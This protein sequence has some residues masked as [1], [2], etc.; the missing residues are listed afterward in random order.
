VTARVTD[1]GLAALV[2]A[3]L[4][5]GALTLFAGTPGAAWLFAVHDGCGFAIALLVIVKLRRV[6]PRLS[7]GA[8]DVNRRAPGIGAA[9]AVVTCLVAGV[10][11]S[12]GL[13]TAPAG[14]SLLS[15]HDA[16]GAILGFAVVAHMVVRAKPLRRR[17]LAGRRQL[18]ATTGLAAVA[19]VAWR[20]QQPFQALLA[21]KG[22]RRRFTGS[23][24]AGSFEGNVFPSTSWVAD[25]PAPIDPAAYRLRIEGLATR[26]LGL[27]LDELSGTDELVA[28]LDCTGGFYSTQRW[29]GVRLGRLLDLAST[30]ASA[31]HVSVTSVTGYR[32][33]FAIDDARGLLLATHVGGAP[34]AHDHGAPVR[35]VVPGA[36]GFEWV[37]WVTRIELRRDPDLGAPLSTLWSSFV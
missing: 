7:R 20:G 26:P 13:A 27:T 31:R 17:H 30:D 19:V 12:G 3:L 9:V 36:R 14:Y 10:L 37:K 21:L 33:S 2:A 8:R 11:W 32:W 23:Y 18:L 16:L 24:E 1:W 4:V 22:A 6:W 28:T 25:D 35:L 15:W 5:T 29:R 34:L